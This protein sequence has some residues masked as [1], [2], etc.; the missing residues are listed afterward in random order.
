MKRKSVVWIV[1]ILACLTIT[2]CAETIRP[3][4]SET[5]RALVGGKSFDA[6]ISG[7]GSYGEGEDKEYT[8][9]ITACEEDMF[10]AAVIENLQ[11]GDEIR[12]GD[13][14]TTTIKEIAPDGA[15]TGFLVKGSD[16]DAYSFYKLE[17][18]LYVAHTDTENPFWRD[19]FTVEVPLEKDIRFLDWSDPENLEAPVERGVDDL[20]Q[21]LYE[22]VNFAPYNTKVT[23]DEDCRL[24][25]FLYNYSP[26][27]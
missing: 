11:T 15:E 5:L 1:L 18:G 25:E 4:A 7:W 23:F 9:S 22:G 17:N 10:D 27:N 8:I 26:W 14:T 12:F 16:Y 13:G 21:L 3:N 6:R 20:F 19:I 24:V 2:A